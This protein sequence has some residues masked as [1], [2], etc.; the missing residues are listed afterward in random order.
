[1]PTSTCEKVPHRLPL[2]QSHPARRHHPGAAGVV[3]IQTGCGAVG[4]NGKFSRDATDINH[5]ASTY[6]STPEP[7]GMAFVGGVGVGNRS[8]LSSTP[9]T[10]RPSPPS[11]T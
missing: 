5:P 1:M 4:P 10:A 9:M 11:T 2:E 7:G 6:I 3:V 8:A